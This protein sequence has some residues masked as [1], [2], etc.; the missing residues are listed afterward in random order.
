[1]I[2]ISLNFPRQLIGYHMFLF[3]ELLRVL[4]FCLNGF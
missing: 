4:K 2:I 3:V 1:M